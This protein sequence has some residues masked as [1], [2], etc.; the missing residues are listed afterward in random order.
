MQG[1]KSD[2]QFYKSADHFLLAKTIKKKEASMFKQCAVEYFKYI[3]NN[4]KKN[5]PSLLSKIF[6]MFKLEINN[7]QKN[8]TSYFLVMENLNYEENTNN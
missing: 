7:Q 3:Y 4:Q 8:Q 6:G 5:K 2:G 1:G